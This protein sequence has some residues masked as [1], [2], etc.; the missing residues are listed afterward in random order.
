[1]TQAQQSLREYL[2]TC[3]DRNVGLLPIRP[4]SG[5]EEIRTMRLC[6]NVLRR[7]EM[8]YLTESVP[9]TTRARAAQTLFGLHSSPM[10]VICRLLGIDCAQAR[11]KIIEWKIKGL[12]GD[13]V[14]GF[15]N[16]PE[17]GK[18]RG[19]NRANKK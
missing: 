11:L 14:F 16:Q 17:S 6:I 15:L 13:P 12:S 4:P 2:K 5:I 7:A 19:D 3:L 10:P 8:D 1:M 18:S 9:K